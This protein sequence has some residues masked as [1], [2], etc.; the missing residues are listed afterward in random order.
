MQNGGCGGGRIKGR[1]P[2]FDN[3]VPVDATRAGICRP[4][5]DKRQKAAYGGKRKMHTCNTAVS[6]TPAAAS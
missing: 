1:I 3:S 2:D 4:Q 6:T 5:D